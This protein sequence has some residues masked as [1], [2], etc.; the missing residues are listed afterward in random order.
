M[1]VHS[2]RLSV[3]YAYLNLDYVWSIFIVLKHCCDIVD[4]FVYFF[5][6]LSVCRHLRFLLLNWFYILYLQLLYICHDSYFSLLFSLNLLCFIHSSTFILVHSCFSSIY[7]VLNMVLNKDSLFPTNI[8]C[9]FQITLISLQNW[10]LISVQ[11]YSC[12]SFLGVIRPLRTWLI[13]SPLTPCLVWSGN[14]WLVQSHSNR[15]QILLF[16][17]GGRPVHHL[18]AAVDGSYMVEGGLCGILWSYLTDVFLCYVRILLRALPR[19]GVYFEDGVVAALVEED[20]F[21]VGL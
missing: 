5:S 14:S 2:S 9:R 15:K 20:G 3:V 18:H 10:N 12:S 21:S 8:R 16:G 1:R 13:N 17:K 19:V 7:M 11:F 4:R 6:F